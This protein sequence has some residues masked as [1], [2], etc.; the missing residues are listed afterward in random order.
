M[1]SP[2]LILSLLLCGISAALWYRSH[3]VSDILVKDS[4]NRHYELVTLSGQFRFTIVDGWI[5]PQPLR[6]FRDAPPPMYPVFGQRPIMTGW[7]PPG[8]AVCR[9]AE[10]VSTVALSPTSAWAIRVSFTTVA[11]P[12]PLLVGLAAAYPAWEVFVARRRRNRRASRLASGLCVACGYDMRFSPHRCPE[13]GRRAATL[14]GT[15]I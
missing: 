13:C 15:T 10:T 4:G 12:Y 3:R 6:H 7:Y 8:I 1:R 11:I 2:F 14:P 9:G 5:S